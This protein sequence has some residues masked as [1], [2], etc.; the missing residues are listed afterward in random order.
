MASPVSALRPS[1]RAGSAGPGAPARAGSTGP[2]G[3]TISELRQ[4]AVDEEISSLASPLRQSPTSQGSVDDT[5]TGSFDVSTNRRLN[6]VLNL[7]FL[8]FILYPR[9]FKVCCS[10]FY[11]LSDSPFYKMP[12]ILEHF[13]CQTSSATNYLTCVLRW[14][15]NSVYFKRSI[16]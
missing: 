5:K 10:P 13:Q 8:K 11:I 4:D 16:P 6:I 12:P 14:Q 9:I 7:I 2:G 15:E 3:P 1:S